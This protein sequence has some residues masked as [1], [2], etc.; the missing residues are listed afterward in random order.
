MSKILAKNQKSFQPKRLVFIILYLI[1]EYI[2]SKLIKKFPQV[3]VFAFD[4]TALMINMNG[5]LSD[6]SLKLII[7]FLKKKQL[8]FS[9]EILIDI[10]ANIGNHSIYFSEYFK[11][12]YAYEPNPA[13]FQLLNF[14]SKFVC[15]KNNI[16]PKMIGLSNK[17]NL[18]NFEINNSNLGASKII[19][20]KSQSK[21]QIISIKVDKLDDIFSDANKVA[22]IKIDVEGH[23]LEA[24]KG[25][26]KLIIKNKPYIIFE[27]HAGEIKNGSSETIEF[28]KKF[29]YKFAKSEKNL[30]FGENFFKKIFSSFLRLFLGHRLMLIEASFF[31]TKF[32]ETILAIPNEE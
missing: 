1:N 4:Q 26:E 27:Q 17:K 15:K 2:A 5:R 9:N 7:S 18:L 19:K 14:N 10:G 11:K 6:D 16:F 30:Y 23:E 25:A 32:Y 28:L 20:N 13:T 21:R 3:S 24:L 31:E 29:G 8:K 12:I 22:V